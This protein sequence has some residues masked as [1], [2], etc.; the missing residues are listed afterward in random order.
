VKRLLL[1]RDNG[2]R[3]VFHIVAD[4]CELGLFQLL[5]LL[6]G[7]KQQRR[8]IH[9]QGTVNE[10][11]SVFHVAGNLKKTRSISGNK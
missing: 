11:G 4:F 10:G 3:T 2:G 6:K 5:I 7:I 8:Q 1:A 9:F